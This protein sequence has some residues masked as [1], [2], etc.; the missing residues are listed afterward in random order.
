M[1]ST[2]FLLS[3]CGAMAHAAECQA[4]DETTL[5]QGLR[6]K[7]KNLQA[8]KSM[9]ATDAKGLAKSLLH[10][11]N[12]LDTM[13]RDDVD[14]AL[15]DAAAALADLS[16]AIQEQVTILQ[17]SVLHASAAVQA[18]HT[19][20]GVIQRAGLWDSAENQAAAVTQC[21][22]ELDAAIAEEAEIC[23]DAA[24]EAAQ[25]ECACDEAR[26]RRQDKEELC[27]AQVNAYEFA[28][29]EH[30]LQCTT[31]Q[32]CHETEVAVYN[33][34]RSDVEDEMVPITAEYIATE[35]SNCL[36]A[37]IIAALANPPM[38]MAA[39]LACLTVDTSGLVIV[40]PETPDA[41]DAC[42]PPSVG[43]PQCGVHYLVD[44]C[45]SAGTSH[46]IEAVAH[47]SGRTASVR[48]CSI[49]GDS[50][51]TQDLDGG[52]QTGKTFTEA[53]GVCEANGLRLCTEEEIG[54]G[55]CCGT[56]CNYDSHQIW[57]TPVPHRVTHDGCLTAGSSPERAVVS[58]DSGVTA[59]VRCCSESGDSCI[60]SAVS[61]GCQ[62][63]KTFLEA[64]T[65]CEADGHRLCTEDELAGG[66]CCGSGCNYDSHSV[67]VN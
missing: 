10:I 17:D 49:G 42:A 19:E 26:T 33:Q 4:S 21:N 14:D 22:D 56:G 11:S 65:I 16:P 39:Q 48:C 1:K 53:Q 57:V 46:A 6:M 59:S 2:F 27:D 37:V 24:I 8:E 67:W 60:T 3:A 25:S 50:C 61:G 15:A 23:S 62:T 9:K 55:V 20:E 64:K 13:V 7:A 18:C 35:Q 66:V 63:G 47:D 41:P 44:G 58:E 34:V 43:E 28:Y 36:M 52:C 51:V 31:F 45:T 5:L 12:N 40:Y 54:G 32:D 30:N 38:D 29:C